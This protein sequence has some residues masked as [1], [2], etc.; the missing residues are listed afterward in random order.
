[1][2]AVIDGVP[3]VIP[4]RG[5][6]TTP[7]MVG[8]SASGKRV[9]GHAAK[10]QAITN[11]EHTLIAMKRLIG[12]RWGTEEVEHTAKAAAFRIVEG[13]E[14]QVGVALRDRTY[15]VAEL[16]AML[17]QDLRGAAEEFL[18]A[19][20]TQA[21]I[22]VPAYF[23]DLQR[24]A[25][26]D[27]GQIAGLEVLR[28]INE[29]TAAA[30]AYGAQLRH[31]RTVVVYDFGGGTFDVSIVRVGGD[32]SFE[33]LGTGGDSFLG[34]EDLDR[35]VI[36]WLADGFQR[37]HGVDLY[38]DRQALQRLKDAAETAKRELST[39]DRAEISLP[40]ITTVGKQPLNLQRELTSAEF[41]RMARPLVARTLTLCREALAAAKLD[42]R[43]VDDLVMVGGS[44]RLPLVLD[45]VERWLGKK[46]SRG[47]NPDEAIAL[48]AARH[49]DSLARGGGVELRDVT[50]QALGFRIPDNQ[51]HVMIE[52]NT[53]VPIERRTT[54]STTRPGQSTI[55]LMVLQGVAPTADDNE[56]LGEFRFRG[57][58]PAHGAK[59][60]EVEVTFA[61]DEQGL[62][63]VRARDVA[64]GHEQSLE[65]VGAGGLGDAVLPG[66]Q[67]EALINEIDRLCSDLGVAASTTT[68]RDVGATARRDAERARA[69]LAPTADP[70]DVRRHIVKL[71]ARRAEL[72]QSLRKK[73]PR[74]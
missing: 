48:G 14:G 60:V 39:M 73:R 27:A 2:A 45:E 36:D 56:L 59:A 9:V 16:S 15:G 1:M 55:R 52:Q 46:P 51:W 37:E 40:F 70:L 47:I 63:R 19:P 4:N 66:M 12:R 67:L 18:E 23:N 26:R 20:V 43:Q 58:T 34:G 7:S 65:I 57:F 3:T 28:V 22:T 49:A 11:P 62:V 25:T 54:V 29:P 10:R 41:D 64:T 50:S 8:I 31:G 24:Q 42:V 17:L 69:L 53:R 33:V 21:V 38:G 35:L 32:G 71:D 68:A 44:S 6:T 13:P 74:R 72:Q 61:L 5:F 30:I